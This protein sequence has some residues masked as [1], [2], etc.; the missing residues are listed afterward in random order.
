M[1]TGVRGRNGVQ[2]RSARMKSLAA[3]D[4][5]YDRTLNKNEHNKMLTRMPL[6]FYIAYV[7]VTFKMLL[8]LNFY[9]AH[10]GPTCNYDV[11][12][13]MLQMPNERIKSCRLSICYAVTDNVF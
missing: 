8:P 7:H 4:L 12:F 11:S 9:N 2:N 3:N 1:T 5:P 6:N 10:V 13:K